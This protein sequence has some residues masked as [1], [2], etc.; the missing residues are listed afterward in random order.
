MNKLPV[1]AALI[2]VL[3]SFTNTT[4]SANA[5]PVAYQWTTVSATAPLPAVG[6]G[7]YFSTLIVDSA[8]LSTGLH[9][10]SECGFSAPFTCVRSGNWQDFVSLSFADI[11]TGH[12]ALDVTFNASDGT[13]TGGIENDGLA[14]NLHLAGSHF[15]WSTVTPLYSD[16]WFQ[17][18]SN[19]E[20]PCGVT[21]FY[22]T[23]NSPTDLRLVATVPEPASI[24]TI[25]TALMLL[26][27]VAMHRKRN[28][29]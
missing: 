2:A 1:V 26:G 5:I 24:I 18:G 12:L 4:H 13:I 3:F 22:K 8:A 17:C 11:N 28:N 23:T 6:P 7:A 19:T 16:Y 29:V 10:V 27:G 25:G 14:Q 21:G 15:A 9:F 20:P